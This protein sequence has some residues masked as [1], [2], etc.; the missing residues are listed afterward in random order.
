MINKE[1]FIVNLQHEYLSKEPIFKA[2][3]TEHNEE[4]NLYR[5]LP[6]PSNLFQGVSVSCIFSTEKQAISFY[7]KHRRAKLE[8]ELEKLFK[9]EEKPSNGKFKR[10]IVY[11]GVMK[12]MK[13]RDKRGERVWFPKDEKPYFDKS[14][15]RPFNT[16]KEKTE[17]MKKNSLVMDGSSNPKRWPIEAGDMRSK[18]YRRENKLE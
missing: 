3:I 10:T 5:M 17:Y 2:K 14:L 9:P 8:K 15:Q 13:Y 18:S 6:C 11:G 7:K 4:T 1:M 16:I 12:D